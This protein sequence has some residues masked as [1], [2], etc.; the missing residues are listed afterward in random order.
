MTLS[1]V[2]QTLK[3]I[4]TVRKKDI[5]E[6]THFRNQCIERKIEIKTVRDIFKKKKILGILK[7]GEDTFKIWFYLDEDKDIN[8]IVNII[9]N[10]RLKLI[11]I[12][13]CLTERRKR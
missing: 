10:K 1:A 4:N 13:P 3:I 12:F 7:Q 6:S 5:I 9:N 11:T 2:W 8:I